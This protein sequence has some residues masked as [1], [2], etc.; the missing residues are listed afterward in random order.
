MSFSLSP[1]QQEFRD[2]VRKLAADK[3]APNAAAADRDARFPQASFDALCEAGILGVAIPEAYGGQGADLLTWTVCIEEVARACAATAVT[4]LV[5]VGAAAI[6]ILGL[7]TEEQ[8]RRWLPKI[9]TGEVLAAYGQSETEAGSDVAGIRT[10]AVPD[11]DA[12]VINGRKAWITN[13]GIAGV[14]VVLAKT[15]PDAGARGITMFLVEPDMAGFAVGKI[16]DKMGL[17]GSYTGELVLDDVRVP[18][19]AVL[20]EVNTGFLSAMG[21]LDKSRPLV[22]AQALGVAQA[23]LDAAVAYAKERHAFGQRIADFQ[24]LQFMIADMQIGIETART[25]VYRAAALADAGDPEATMAASIAK[26]Y[27]T[28]VAMKVTTDAVQ[29]LGGA[30]Y[31]KDFPVER[32]MRD[33]KVFQIYEGTNQIQRWI[34]AR[35]LLA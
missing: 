8:K 16:E 27:G 23:A 21:L 12:W 34:V 19:D 14:Y 15:D 30:G 31:T 4:L 9:A 25:M 6:P 35:R 32:H 24:G 10:R 22:A 13:A 11:G 33:A 7:G 20:G 29:V 18:G 26:C 28:D 3:V 17:R 5:S 1:E 2:V